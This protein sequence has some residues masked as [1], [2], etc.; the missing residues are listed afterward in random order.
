RSK[1]PRRLARYSGDNMPPPD[2]ISIAAQAPVIPV[3]T[4]EHVADAV[5]LA[6]ALV[7][8]GLS[9]IEVTLRT[10]A[11]LESMK[12]IIS[13]V[14]DAVVG[15]GTVLTA[16]DVQ[17]AVAAGANF[18]VSPGTS[19]ALA[20]ALASAPVPALPGCATVSEAM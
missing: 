16:D 8:G 17:A 14:A 4:I 5:P 12:A 6:R 2:V 11:A 10:Q 7:A 18:L 1:T 20:E 13:D 15:V 9:V 3:L 19:D